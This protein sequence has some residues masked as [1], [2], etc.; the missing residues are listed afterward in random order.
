[1][2]F[3]KLR[4][5]FSG[6]AFRINLIAAATIF[7][8]LT[9]AQN[10]R[11]DY[12][13]TVLGAASSG[14][15]SPFWL[16]NNQYGKISSQPHSANISLAIKQE[17]DNPTKLFDYGFKIDGL[18]RT[19]GFE[20]A[21][22]MHEYHVKARFLF[23]DLIAG[24]REEHLGNQDSTLSCGGILFSHNAR[25]MP[26]LAAGIEHF[27]PVPFT[28]GFLEIKGALSHGWFT[29]NI[30]SSDVLMHHKYLYARIGG[31]LPVRLQYGL[32]HVAQWAGNVPGMDPQ[33]AGFNDYKAI[34]FGKA[35]GSD[36]NISD[37]I[38]ALGNH[39][40][41]QS[42]RIDSKIN[43]FDIGLYWQN[44]SE[45]GPVRLLWESMNRP[46]G[47]WGISVRNRDFPYIKGILYEYLNTTD[48][49]G[50]YH[51]KDGIIYGG[52]D[53]YFNNGI[54]LSGWSY[55]SR[56]IGTPLVTSPLYN[57]DNSVQFQNNRVQVHHF[58]MEGEITGYE[59]RLMAS[60]SK[61]YGIYGN[62]YPE[63]KNTSLYLN[64]GK[65]LPRFY[66]MKLGCSI[67]ADFGRLYGNSTG[68][69][70]SISR[71]GNLFRY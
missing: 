47:L 42:M 7:S 63:I 71:F 25:P 34:F 31:N 16:Q 65:Q 2:K 44:I 57:G 22:F 30:Y 24:A 37:Q 28:K 20:T 36:A 64:M 41:S 33:P 38:N 68:C 23:V 11:V 48:Q 1:M 32:D 66:N 12:N 6:P 29:D 21:A 50:P 19:D 70:I 53:S 69:I 13:A 60:F 17:L 51:D 18:L 26:K 55:F 40:I 9:H 8:A 67:G 56:S 46:D 35:G 45:D 39:I 14:F 62:P 3:M 43:K 10:N 4:F 59:Y 27:K 54:Y 61:N 52:G 58:G 15:F 49:S 5:L